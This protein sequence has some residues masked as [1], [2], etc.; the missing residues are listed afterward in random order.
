MNTQTETEEFTV[1]RS[2]GHRTH[3]MVRGTA[4]GEKNSYTQVPIY[5]EGASLTGMCAGCGSVN[6]HGGG[7]PYCPG[8]EPKPDRSVAAAVDRAT[9]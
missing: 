9:G 3:Y 7:G 5:P 4:P 8:Y 6:N 2:Y 1:I